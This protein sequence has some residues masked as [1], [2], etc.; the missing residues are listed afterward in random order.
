MTAKKNVSHHRTVKKKKRQ[1]EAISSDLDRLATKS[2]LRYSLW[3]LNLLQ[4]LEGILFSKGLHVQDK[5]LAVNMHTNE[6]LKILI[7][8]S[9]QNWGRSSQTAK[10]RQDIKENNMGR[11][12]DTNQDFEN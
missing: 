10:P 5:K 6:Y 2:T 8:S 4:T 3:H 7:T 9:L 11:E 1:R 12:K